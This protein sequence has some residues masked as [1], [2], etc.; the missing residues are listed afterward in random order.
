[1]D[2]FTG[3]KVWEYPVANGRTGV[4]STAGGLVFMGGSG[5]LVAIDGKTG[6][7]VWHVD[8]GQLSSSSPMTYIVGGKQYIVLPG[9]GVIVAYALTE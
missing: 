2:I 1:M 3:M 7:P 5:G 6:K 9:T 8:M 4:L